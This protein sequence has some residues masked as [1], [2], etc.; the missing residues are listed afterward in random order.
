MSKLM[1]EEQQ[2]RFIPPFLEDDT[3]ML[4]QGLT[5][6]NAGSDNLLPN[7]DPHAGV[8]TTARREGNEWIIN[9][10]K[11]FIANGKIAKLVFLTTRTD[12][13][14]SIIEGT[15][16]FAI[17]AGTPGFTTGRVDNKM[18]QR[19]A[20]NAEL[21]FQDCRIPDA[22]R[23][24]E[25]NQGLRSLG[26]VSYANVLKT[27]GTAL[28]VARAAYDAGLRYARQ[29]VQGSRPIIEH[30]AVGMM[31]ADMLMGIEASRSLIWRM[32]WAVDH[33]PDFDHN[34]FRLAKVFSC[35]MTVEVTLKALEIFGGAGIMKDSPIEK[36]HRDAVTLLHSGGTHQI[37]RIKVARALAGK[38]VRG[39]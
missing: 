14:R 28:G 35:E 26:Q 31:L 30:Q 5:E 11:H 9:G 38:D 25:V 10:R 23:I 37:L 39:W 27:A 2:A 13:A 18:G 32:G 36:I 33:Q 6:P 3:F 12:S 34:L 17:P 7:E 20:N 16:L 24:G 8:S 22:N 19:L 29:R 4:A 15:T 21:I 1:N